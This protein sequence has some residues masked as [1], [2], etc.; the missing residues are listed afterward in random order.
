MTARA[1]GTGTAGDRR[2]RARKLAILFW[3]MLSRGEDYA[4]QQ[5]SLTAKKLRRL[6][7]RRTPPA[8]QA[9]PGL[10]RASYGSARPKSN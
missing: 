3:C 10:E 8:V 2:D 5:P 4:H 7:P 1:P 9:A 6:D